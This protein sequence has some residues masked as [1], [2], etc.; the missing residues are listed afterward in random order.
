MM[1]KGTVPVP[2]TT[3]ALSDDATVQVRGLSHQVTTAAGTET[4]FRV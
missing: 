2:L 4:P 1:K 3:H